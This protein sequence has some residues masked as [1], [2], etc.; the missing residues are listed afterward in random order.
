MT[1]RE[2]VSSSVRMGLLCAAM[3]A[4]FGIWAAVTAIGD[5]SVQPD[6]SQP[7]RRLA[8]S[9]GVVYMLVAA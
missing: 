8:G 6:V 3:G 5:T 7:A 1:A 2:S 4:F 9:L